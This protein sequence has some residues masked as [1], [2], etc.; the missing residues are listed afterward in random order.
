M[1]LKNILIFIITLIYIS[2]HSQGLFNNGARIL[3]NGGAQIYVAGAAAG[4]Y[5]NTSGGLITPSASSSIT[6]EGNWVNNAANT[7][8]SVDG[9]GV[10]L[11]GAA[12]QITGTNPT[13]FYNLTLSGTNTK[14]LAVNNVTVGGQSAFTGI[15][16]LGSRPLDLNSNTLQITNPALGAI[17]NG[18]G[19]IISET[20]AMV[21][22]SVV[23]WFMRASTGAHVYPFGTTGGVSIP[24]TF[25]VTTAMPSTSAY[26]DVST[27]PTAAS[28]NVP[29][30]GLSNVAAVSFFYCPNNSTSGNTCASNSVIDRWWDITN[31]SA[32]TGDLTFTYRGAENTL[33]APLNTGNIGAQFWNGSAWIGN[34]STFGSAA[35]VTSGTGQVTAVGMSTFCPWV[36]SSVTIPLPIDLLDFSANC[37]NANTLLLN[38]SSITETNLLYFDILNS[39]DGVS[40]SKIATVNANGNSNTL[41]NYAYTVNNKNEFGPYYR[42]R[43]VDAD[44]T[45]RQSKVIFSSDCNASN[46]IPNLYYNEQSGIVLTA[47]SSINTN[48]TLLIMDAS[49]K[50]INQNTFDIQQGYNSFNVKPQLANGIYLVTL[51]YSNNQS[52][53]KKIPVMNLN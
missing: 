32:V 49:G 8:F 40:F 12:Q 11:N 19:Y 39:S 21:N 20:N 15:L 53:S 41:Q 18:G 43:M 26:I 3:F 22:P 35:A 25:N 29:W 23:R 37:K 24:F 6:I 45:S 50:I 1:K 10:V 30:A 33:L 44:Y 27:R 42:L 16:A 47:N 46:T 48:Y 14:Q 17:T 36:L 9:G 2:A 38:W 4:N 31:S 34:N 7:S 51:I 28:N 5:S 52:I 13:A